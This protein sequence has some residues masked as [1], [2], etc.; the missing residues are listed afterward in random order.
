MKALLK[1]WFGIVVVGTSAGCTHVSPPR[2]TSTERLQARQELNRWSAGEIVHYQSSDGKVPL[3]ARL[4]RAR[5][6]T[7]AVIIGLHGLETHSLWFAPLAQELNRS[8]IA[9]LAIDRRGSGLNA[10]ASGKGQ[11][12]P[13]ETYRMWLDDLSAATRVG[14]RFSPRVYVLGNSWGGNPVVAWA[15]LPEASKLARGVILLTPGLA[16]RKPNLLQQLD[17]LVSPDQ[18]LLGTCLGVKDYSRQRS[19]WGLLEEDTHAT[20]DVLA[21]FFR[22]TKSMRDEALRHLP[23]VELPVMVIYAGRDELMINCKIQQRLKQGLP[24]SLLR[25]STLSDNWH[26]VLIEN[27]TGVARQILYWTAMP[28]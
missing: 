20:R 12:G 6:A 10:G 21:R 27:T 28:N 8:G 22:E 17:I 25:E 24:K 4:Y 19:T 18:R 15:E 9:V 2:L 23:K 13:G 16:A 3:R 26:L 1:L 11:M 5:G 7:K 14:A